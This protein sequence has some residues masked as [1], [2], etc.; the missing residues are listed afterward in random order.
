MIAYV[1][2]QTISVMQAIRFQE[3]FCGC[4]LDDCIPERSNE[5]HCRT[6]ERVVII[7]RIVRAAELVG[8]RPVLVQA[9]DQGAVPFY[10][11]YSFNSFPT[12]NQTLFLPMDEIV[13]AL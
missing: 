8:A 5:A 1:A 2:D 10:A 9:V 6:A 12:N 11:R 7:D 4:K 3:R 13:A